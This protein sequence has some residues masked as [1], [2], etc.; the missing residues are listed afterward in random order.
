MREVSSMSYLAAYADRIREQLHDADAAAANAE[1]I[2]RL[3]ALR[4]P[5]IDERLD[6]LSYPDC[7]GRTLY[8]NATGPRNA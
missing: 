2:S 7:D 1:I 5:V 3:R 6:V 4:E 8:M